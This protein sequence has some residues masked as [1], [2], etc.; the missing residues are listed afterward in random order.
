[1][2]VR[3]LEVQRGMRGGTAITREVYLNPTHIISVAADLVANESMLRESAHLG[4]PD[5]T[6]FSKITLQEGTSPRIIVVVGSP[7]EVYQK[8]KTKQILKG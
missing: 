7:T 8:I 6:S 2:L 1:M 5:G 3:L 4:L